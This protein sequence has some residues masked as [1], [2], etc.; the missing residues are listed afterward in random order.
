MP[1]YDYRCETCDETREEFQ[2]IHEDS[3]TKCPVC[4]G[5]YEKQISL[6]SGAMEREYDVPIE[7]HSIAPANAAEMTA[8]RRRNPG[9]E[10]RDGVPIAR[11][12]K[13]KLRILDAEG[14]EERN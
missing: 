11:T 4:G 3:M 2:S 7:M 12:R 9:V 10:M 14:F 13:E 8:F 1:L 5:R 6:T